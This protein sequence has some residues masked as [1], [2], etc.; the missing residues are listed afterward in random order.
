M[1]RI[2]KLVVSRTLT[3]LGAWSNS[4][5]MDGDLLESVEKQ[6]IDRDVIV[7]GSASVVHALAAHDLVDEYR[8]LL[9]PSALG[10]G[11]RLFTVETAP[12]H[13]LLVSAET[14]G[15]AVL[16]RYQRPSG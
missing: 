15:A 13:L 14:S 7:A 12:V 4:S 2:P 10:T 5:L 16:L 1:N 8:I 3:D 11:A 9:F 6:K